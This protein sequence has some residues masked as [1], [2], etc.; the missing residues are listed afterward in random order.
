MVTEKG[1]HSQL[2]I[3]NLKFSL[4]QPAL[5]TTFNNR[6]A[7]NLVFLENRQKTQQHGRIW[8]REISLN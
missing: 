5:Y 3:A 4:N 6:N 8:L 1:G 2:P 7:K